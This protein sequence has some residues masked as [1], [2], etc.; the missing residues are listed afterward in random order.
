MSSFCHNQ[1]IKS[2]FV[3]GPFLNAVNPETKEMDAGE[4]NRLTRLIDYFEESG[5]TVYNAHRREQWG[6]AF[7]GPDECAPLDFNEISASDLFIAFPGSPA[8]PG[9]HIEVG[10][11]SALGKPTVLLL[12]EDKKH[13]FLITGLPCVSNVEVMTYSGADGFMSELEPALERVMQR[14]LALPAE[15]RNRP[16]PAKVPA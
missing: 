3:G 4:K 2:V 8:S 12:E 5:C 9:T 11:A 10:W 1:G 13:T 7:L 15:D 16:N 14:H 6:K